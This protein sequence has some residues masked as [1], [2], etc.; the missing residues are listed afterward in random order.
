V[1][2]LFIPFA[3]G[4]AIFLFG[5]QLMRIGLEKLAGQHLQTWLLRF[6]ATSG[7]SFLTGIFST[8]LLQSS[9]AVT[10][11]TI[12][13]VNLQLLSFS[14]SIGIILGSNIGTTLTTEILALHIEDFAIPLLLLSV[15]LY[16]LPWDRLSALSFVSGG[17]GCIFLG[18][19]TMQW[20]AKPLQAR[21]LIDWMLSIGDHPILTGVLA[22]VLLTALIQS[23][24]ATIAMA[25]G[26]CSSGVITLPF[27]LAIVLGSNIGTCVTSL[28]ATFRT[29]TAAKQVAVAHLL[30]NV[31]GVTLFAPLVPWMSEVAPLL[32]SDPSQQLAH[33][34][35]LFNVVCSLLVLPF[36]AQFAKGVVWLV[37][38]RDLNNS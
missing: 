24:S 23:S 9:S 8:A 26:L 28:L 11:L 18:M 7:R 25:M 22:G 20:L 27:A 35:T 31:A 3:T 5:L 36:T 32:T 1:K 38:Q 4:I 30:L 2:D 13:F 29:N 19:E 14:H 10:V 21:G 34:Q 15:P 16:F 6:T 33:M 37:P 12:S 17:F